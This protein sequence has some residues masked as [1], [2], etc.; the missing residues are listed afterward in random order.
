MKRCAR[1]QYLAPGH[2]QTEP[3]SEDGSSRGSLRPFLAVGRRL[4]GRPVGRFGV[5]VLCLLAVTFIS[6]L[7]AWHVGRETRSTWRS[8]QRSHASALLTTQQLDAL[9]AETLKRIPQDGNLSKYHERL[10]LTWLRADEKFLTDNADDAETRFERGVVSRRVA[11]CF[12]LTGDLEQAKV[13]YLQAIAL[14]EAL[15]R[16][17]PAVP[18]YVGEQVDTYI[19]LGWTTRMMGDL[20]ESDDAFQQAAALIRDERV[21]GD[22][23]YAPT[24]SYHPWIIDVYLLDNQIAQALHRGAYDEVVSRLERSVDILQRLATDYPEQNRYQESLAAA[25]AKLEAARRQ[26]RQP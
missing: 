7:N 24:V 26:F 9:F 10:L 21:T 15:S 14:F 6:S 2:S 23:S 17:D 22:P 11:Q 8:L 18:S 16:D 13:H 19:R 25:K 5:V 3:Q 4:L 20:R 12:D 1:S